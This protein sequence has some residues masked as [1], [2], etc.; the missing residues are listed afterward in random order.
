[1][2]FAPRQRKKF[3]QILWGGWG[4]KQNQKTVHRSVGK[5]SE[6]GT[7]LH[8]R[9]LNS[10]IV[11]NWFFSSEKVITRWQE[12]SLLCVSSIWVLVNRTN[13]FGRVETQQK[14]GKIAWLFR[15]QKWT[16]DLLSRIITR[17][18]MHLLHHKHRINVIRIG[19]HV[20]GNKWCCVW[21]PNI[22]LL[23]GTTGTT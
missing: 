6:K 12:P 18:L 13:F 2:A 21:W 7:D 20:K 19:C 9:E 22:P 8:S 11:A 3:D 16:R 5:N 14:N 4:L 23:N 1:M 15:Q 17:T 10:R